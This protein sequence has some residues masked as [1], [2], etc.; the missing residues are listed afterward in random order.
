MGGA[1]G[2]FLQR[3][4]RASHLVGRGA[5]SHRRCKLAGGFAQIIQPGIRRHL[6]GMGIDVVQQRFELLAQSLLLLLHVAHPA[7]ELRIVLPLLP[8]ERFHPLRQLAL[9]LIEF[10]KPLLVLDQR[11]DMREIVE[12]LLR[13]LGEHVAL[14]AELLANGVKPLRRVRVRRS[15]R[16]ASDAANLDGRLLHRI[17]GLLQVFFQRL[18]QIEGQVPLGELLQLLCIAADLLGELADFF[19]RLRRNR[20]T[21]VRRVEL[22]DQ[23]DR[24]AASPLRAGGRP[25]RIWKPE[26]PARRAKAS[27]SAFVLPR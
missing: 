4:P 20:M 17:S 15:R 25:G 14:P 3:G 2:K 18:V 19:E 26:L 1:A 5:L 6:I 21:R 24:A 11:I 7:L 10:D 22:L 12:R 13:A 9:A 16:G 23:L 27:S 8:N